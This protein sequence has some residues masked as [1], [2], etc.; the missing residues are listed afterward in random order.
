MMEFFDTTFT[1]V[2]V[3][4]FL[5]D[6]PGGWAN[7]DDCGDYPCTGPWNALLSFEGTT[8]TGSKPAWAT[9]GTFQIIADNP[10]FSQY[11]DGC[12]HDEPMNAWVCQAESLGVLLFESLDEDR[13]DRSMQPIYVKRQGTE[14]SN[15]L[16]AMMDHVW[17]G[18]YSG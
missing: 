15:V 4:A 9:D 13:Q 12:T 3:P 1:D 8:W 10:G 2:D 5:W 11:V 16:N 6:P 14:M 18:F 7:L 17:D